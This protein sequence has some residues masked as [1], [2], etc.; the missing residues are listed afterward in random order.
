MAPTRRLSALGIRPEEPVRQDTGPKR[1]RVQLIGAVVA[2]ALAALVTLV[3]WRWTSS[4]VLPPGPPIVTVAIDE[5]RFEVDGPIPSG[6][7]VLRFVNEGE[8]LHRPVLLP[9]ARGLPPIDE[10]ISDAESQVVTPFASTPTREPGE[11]G[12]FAVD[13]APGHRYAII[14][15]ERNAD[16]KGHAGLG[17]AMEFVAGGP[18][19]R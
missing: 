5:H 10:M 6:R 12:V 3:L 11:T 4:D 19:T 14:C 9:L 2:V 13:L 17:E 16:G 8:S 1:R 15:F 7:V 18:P